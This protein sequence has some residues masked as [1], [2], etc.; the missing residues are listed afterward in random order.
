MWVGS[1][2]PAGYNNKLRTDPFS[3]AI[4]TSLIVDLNP[5]SD[6]VLKLCRSPLALLTTYLYAG[7]PPAPHM[8]G[9]T[10]CNQDS[11]TIA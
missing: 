8:L 5:L 2:Y 6:E 10:G 11:K 7:Q 1:G 9:P 3:L 4:L